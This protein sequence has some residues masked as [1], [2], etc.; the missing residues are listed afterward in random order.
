MKSLFKLLIAAVVVVFMAGSL[1]SCG[2]SKQA[3]KNTQSF[4]HKNSLNKKY[5]IGSSKKQKK[6]TKL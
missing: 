2:S 6:P 4:Q 1:S 3:T 5:V